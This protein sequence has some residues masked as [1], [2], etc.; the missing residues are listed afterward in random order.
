MSSRQEIASV[1]SSAT[2][3]EYDIKNV[4]RDKLVNYTKRDLAYGLADT[5]LKN[6][7]TLPI[8]HKIEIENTTYLPDRTHIIKINLISD[9]ELK[10]LKEI[11]RRYDDLLHKYDRLLD[12]I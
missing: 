2:I 7:K 10:R 12:R 1:Y 6:H 5:I 3:N 8:Q 11:E 4:P 9:E